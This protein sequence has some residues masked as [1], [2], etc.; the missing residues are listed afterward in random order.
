MGKGHV[1]VEEECD[2]LVEESADLQLNTNV[3]H[4]LKRKR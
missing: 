1:P 2:A 3:M 4:W